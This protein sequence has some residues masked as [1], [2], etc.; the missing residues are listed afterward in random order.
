MIYFLKSKNNLVHFLLNKEH[1]LNFITLF[2]ILNRHH[3]NN[4]Q[5]SK[6]KNKNQKSFIKFINVIYQKLE[7]LKNN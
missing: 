7:I 1:Q 6:L 2:N 4:H 3:N 5:N